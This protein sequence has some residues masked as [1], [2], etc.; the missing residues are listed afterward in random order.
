MLIVLLGE[1]AAVLMQSSEE[2]GNASNGLDEVQKSIK[3]TGD[4]AASAMSEV[5]G[6]IDLVML[7]GKNKVNLENALYSLGQ[8][9]QKGKGDFSSYSVAGRANLTALYSTITAL[10]ENSTKDGIV[11]QQVLADNL[12]ALYNFMIAGGYAT[13]ESLGIVQAAILATGRTAQ[14]VA[15]NFS[16]LD[17]GFKS[18]TISA[19][20]S[21]TALEKLDDVLQK[22]LRNFNVKIGLADSLE[23]LGASIAENGKVFGYG[24]SGMRENLK[25]L[26]GTISAF[27][28]SS[29]GDLTVFRGNLL[30][31]RAAM[32]RL[33]VTGGPALAMIDAALSKTGKKGKASAKEIT[34]I[35][36]AIGGSI[37]KNA[38]TI[39][40]Y[41]GDL[42]AA[43]SDA[44]SNRYGTAEA[45]DRI[46]SAFNDMR[47][48]ADDAKQAIS[49]AQAEILNIRADRNI[50]E[51]QLSVAIR[52]G[53]T[54]R[55]ES[56]R[57]KLAKANA[58]LAE[59][60]KKVNE[61]QQ[62]LN[63]TLTGTSASAVENRAKLRELIQSGN[64]YLLT[65]AKSG[66]S[67]ADLKIEAEKL[68]AEFL[69]Q[70]RSLGFAET[71]LQSY[72]KAFTTDFTTIVDGVPRDVSIVVS[73]DPALEALKKFVKDANTILGGIVSP[74]VKVTN[75]GSSAR[76]APSPAPPPSPSPAP[77]PAPVVAKDA[78]P[79]GLAEYLANYA[80]LK[81][82]MDEWNKK[83]WFAQMVTKIPHAAVLDNLL[84][85]IGKFEAS[86]G[87]LKYKPYD[88]R[89]A[90][91]TGGLVQGPGT[92][93]SDSI[94][95]RVSS[96]EYIVQANAVR[97]Y[98][99]DFMNALNNIQVQRQT[100][101]G[102]NGG[103]SGMV[104]L[105]PE[106]RQLLRAAIERPINLY[107]DNKQLASSVS[108][109]NVSLARRGLN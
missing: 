24:T 71:E 52:Y 37:K 54:L 23:G 15:L 22:V 105:S 89:V 9:L 26:E 39:A 16:S 95:V 69:A 12:Q 49:E 19:G 101:S 87:T 66:M 82:E 62:V 91:A 43:L 83:D 88:V 44:F 20:T 31:L 21:K 41:V 55:A 13:A 92:A 65:L 97:Y 11:N 64:A 25:A 32:Q 48:S 77:A 36:N 102:S 78:N 28:E 35:F 5:K 47:S 63:K 1:L 2:S 70:G 103:S 38:Q 100:S 75:S 106:D 84:K 42:N 67:S 8:S 99:T 68:S 56:I 85:K 74:T 4:E 109:G 79:P 14:A 57:S 51:Y 72:L 3:K 53:D 18:T 90:Y 59:Q 94:P 73:T 60:E 17:S 81:R 40:D 61:N 98:G 34:A 6:F 10:T 7:S 80:A 76:P 104:Y 29:N 96:G 27:K 46:S 33:G 58:D 86:V 93:T 45:M 30:S 107:A 108:S 50:L